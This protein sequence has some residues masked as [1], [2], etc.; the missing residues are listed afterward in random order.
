MPQSGYQW[1]QGAGLGSDPPVPRTVP[2][3]SHCNSLSLSFVVCKMRI[4][5]LTSRLLLGLND[6]NT[7]AH[8]V[9]CSKNGVG[10]ERSDWGDLSDLWAVSLVAWLK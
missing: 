9:K 5:I 6:I 2:L 10:V 4:V 8:S 3:G 7:I 1:R